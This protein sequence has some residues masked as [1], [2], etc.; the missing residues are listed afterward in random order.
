MNRWTIAVLL[1]APLALATVLLGSG[2]TGASPGGTE[3]VSVD[4]AGNPANDNSRS[5]S[6]STDGRYVA[7]VSNATNLMPSDSNSFFEDVFVHDRQTGLTEVVSVNSAGEQADTWVAW[8]VISADGRYVAFASWDDKLVPGD[9][10]NVCGPAAIT[11]CMDVFVHDRQTGLTERV[12]VDSAGNQ[13]N[14]DSGEDGVSEWAY[15]LFDIS[16]DGRYVAFASSADNLVPGD[17]NGGGDVFV[18]DRQTGVTERVSVDSAGNQAD[19]GGWDPAISANGRYVAFGSSATNLVPNDTD[20]CTLAG[21]RWNCR[22]IFV[23]DRQTGVTQRVSVS[24]AGEEAN[25]ESGW[26][27]ISGDGRFVAF[28]SGA[29]NLVPGDTNDFCE[30]DADGVHDDNCGDI[31]VHDRQTGVTERV[32][33]DSAGNQANGESGA[34]TIIS[35]D[36]R[37][38]AFE[39]SATNL[40]PGDT[41]TCYNLTVPGTCPDIFVHDRQTG[42]TER[43]SVD[44]AGNQGNAPSESFSDRPGISADGRYVAFASSADNLVPGDTNGYGDVFVHDRGATAPPPAT[45]TPPA[46]PYRTLTWDPGWQNAAWS[47]ADSTS[48]DEA[49]ACADGS[50]AAAYRFTDSGLQR[51]FPDR[52]D[53]S[54]MGPVGEHDAFLILITDPVTC[55]MPLAAASGSNRT[56]QWEAGWNNA[57]WSG[58]DGTPPE[59][60]FACADDSYAAAYRYVDGGL[61]RFFPDRS[62]ISNMGPLDKYDAFLILVTASV[63]CSMPI[64]P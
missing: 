57:S 12:S 29:T 22:D 28:Y 21:H 63:S 6:I 58:A 11:N 27:T 43:V 46:G 14:G 35:A 40:V 25:G 4:S 45:P 20:A 47:G 30:R 44:S 8:A 39:S 61:E 60:A 16:G 13:G 51:Y 24:A 50:Y 7:F 2:L 37:F 10:N 59:D 49:F 23:H 62:D 18:H 32:N 9:T 42:V 41:N 31:F 1:V 26:P 17:T 34:S 19:E 5:P 54:N 15:R 56:L 38:L 36:G 53:I 55:Y 52:P 64:A 3:L 48:P 33:V